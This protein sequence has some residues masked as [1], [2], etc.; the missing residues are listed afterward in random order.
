VSSPARRHLAN[1]VGVLPEE[2]DRALALADSPKGYT[3]F[4]LPKVGRACG[5]T[6]AAPAAELKSVQRGLKILLD[7]LPV[8]S[9]AHGFRRGRSIVTAAK[10]H[11]NAQAILSVDLEDFFHTITARRVRAMLREMLTTQV[12]H[13]TWGVPIHVEDDIA[14]LITT[15]ATRPV[16]MN[17]ILPQG[18]PT[19]PVLANIVARP[20]DVAI[21]SIVLQQARSWVYTRYADDLSIS[22]TEEIDESFRDRILILIREFGFTPHPGKTSI[23]STFSGSKHYTQK[24]EFMGLVLDHHTKTV[25]IDR[26]RLRK[27]RRVIHAASA[28]S[29]MRPRSIQRVNGIMSFTRMVYGE[30]P[31]VL[32]GPYDRFLNALHVSSGGL[33]GTTEA[34]SE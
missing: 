4:T 7:S 2:V 29:P 9:A 30:I 8:S 14:D 22:A 24:L 20:L 25:R 21:Q 19:S 1:I 15:L 13:G 11:I 18:A 28:E 34:G 16:G 17:R 5:R 33:L 32:H 23:N 3:P 31:V 26:K 10:A 6:I 12:M 27:F